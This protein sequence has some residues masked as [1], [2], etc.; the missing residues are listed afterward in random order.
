MVNYSLLPFFPIDIKYTLP[1][2]KT[3]VQEKEKEQAEFSPPSPSDYMN[4]AE[5]NLFHPERRIP[6][7][8]KVEPELPK[9]DF[10]VYGT[11]VSDDLKIA[12]LEDLK[13]PRTTPGRGKRQTAVKKG[14]LF[15]GFILKEVEADKIVMVRGEDTMTVHVIDKRKTKMRESSVPVDQKG[16]AQPAQQPQG[17]PTASTTRRAPVSL[18]PETSP[19][20]QPITR[21]PRSTA[22]STVID[23]FNRPGR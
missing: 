1:S 10:V 2:E 21:P 12:Y 19:K 13:S 9:P 22:E 5:E 3:H 11:M 23:F 14:D 20:D 4:I 18:Q 16:P 15:S 6:P 8:K 17:K 7:E